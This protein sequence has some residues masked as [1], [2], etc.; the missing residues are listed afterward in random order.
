MAY[1]GIYCCIHVYYV[2]T[3]AWKPLQNLLD[4]GEVIIRLNKLDQTIEE[5]KSG[6]RKREKR[7]QGRLDLGVMILEDSE[8]HAEFEVYLED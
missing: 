3:C 5:E 8:C 1:A 2:R 4:G 7:N 6:K